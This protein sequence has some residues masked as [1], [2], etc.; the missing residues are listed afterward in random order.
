MKVTIVKEPVDS[1][2]YN[3]KTSEDFSMDYPVV[4][5][6]F[7]EF[8]WIWIPRYNEVLELTKLLLSYKGSAWFAEQLKE[9]LKESS[10][11]KPAAK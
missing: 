10:F 5:V 8:N 2:K 9:L 11:Q 6:R 1:S 7:E 3:I 4:Y